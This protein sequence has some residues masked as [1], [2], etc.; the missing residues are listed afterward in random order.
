MGCVV[1][2]VFMIVIA[3]SLLSAAESFNVEE[4]ERVSGEDESGGNRP[5]ILERFRA[6]LGLNQSPSDLSPSPSPSPAE[7]ARPVHTHKHSR[8]HQLRLH[9]SRPV[10]KS[11]RHEDARK[12]VRKILVAVLVSTGI[13][14]LICTIVAFWV[15]KRF[16]IRTEE[17]AE[18]L[19]IT[20]ETGEKTAKQK[21]GFDLFDL[22]THGMDVEEHSVSSSGERVTPVQC[23][24]SDEEESF[25][26]CGDPNLS[27]VRLSNA[28]ESSSANVKTNSNSSE[29]NKPLTSDQFHLTP[30]PCNSETKDV[31]SLAPPPPPPPPPPL[32]PSPVTYRSSFTLSSP[33]S[34]GSTSS[35]ALLRSSSPAMSDSSSL[36]QIPWNDLP[37][38]PN[39]AK[40]SLPSSTIPPP[41]CPPPSLKENAYSF[42]APP[43]PPPSK[44]PQFM[45]FGKEGNLL[46]KLKPLH[47]DKVRAAPDRSMVW[48]KLRWSSFELDEEMIES[49]FG[50]NQHGSMKNGDASNK[51][52][53]PSKHILEAKR[54]QNLTILLKA[55]NL[56]AE[57][58][59]EAIEQGTGLRLRQLEALVKMVPTQEEQAKLLSYEGDIGEYGC[60]EK[61]VIAILRIPFAFQRVEAMLYRETFEDEVNHLRNSF[62]MLEE[63]CKELRSSRLFLK[64]LEAV[65]KTG[66]RMNVGTSRGGAKAFKLDALLRLSDVKGTDGKTS[67]LHFVVQEI[68]RSEGI[69]VSGSIMGK[70][71][72]KNK[73]RTIE[74]REN[75]YRRM[76]LD[77][78]SGLSTE[79]HNVKR[80]ATTDLKVLASATANLNEGMAKLQELVL[81]GLCGD[82]RSGN[83]VSAMKGFLSYVKKTMELVRKDEEGVMGSVREITEYFHGNVSKEETN[84]LRIFV[85]VRDFL[86]MLDNVC[87]SFKIGS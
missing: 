49:L 21:S 87:K 26:S 9:K 24:S 11:K 15:C 33:F 34:T 48:D 65:L 69:R 62:S 78:V 81:K 31:P 60:T 30:S 19:S 18:K 6:L 64:L 51:T 1:K 13:T 45:A 37:S 47:W 38:P 27:N 77:L 32:R 44:L 53:S 72:Q 58:A 40:P 8:P 71:S 43:P 79:L 25:H 12:R 56:S 85:I 59:C 55:L 57:H 42:K 41:P 22:S 39:I 73:S 75:D 20:S 76:G 83:F 16:K 66:N 35:S 52:P 7:A 23:C 17:P 36:S 74:E 46:P 10:Y 54:L 61:F 14:I 70:I 50:Y 28:S 3:N 4:L 67:L 2:C 29:P 5:L 63:A 86:G 82:E 80:A 68:I 84:P